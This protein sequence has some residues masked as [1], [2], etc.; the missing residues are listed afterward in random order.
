MKVADSHNRSDD[1]YTISKLNKELH[2]LN[3]LYFGFHPNYVHIFLP[4]IKSE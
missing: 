3:T 2:Q 1:Y 4:N